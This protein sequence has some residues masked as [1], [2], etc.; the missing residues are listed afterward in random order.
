MTEKM[1]ENLKRKLGRALFTRPDVYKIYPG[2]NTILV[3][4]NDPSFCVHFERLQE[5]RDTLGEFYIGAAIKAVNIIFS[6][7]KFNFKEIE[8]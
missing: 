4:A 6:T 8:E 3:K 1:I 2:R 7:D 5:L